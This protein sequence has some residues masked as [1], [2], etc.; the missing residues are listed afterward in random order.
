M[1]ESAADEGTP[2]IGRSD[3]VRAMLEAVDR[4]APTEATVLVTG[5]TG[6]G[7]ELVARRIHERS[8]RAGPFVAVNTASLATGVLESELF[9]HVRGAFTG[10]T[11]DRKGLFGAAEGGTLFLDEI[12]EVDNGVQHR[13]LRVLQERE[14]IPVGGERPQSIDV[15]IVAAT[16]R[17]LQEAMGAGHFRQDLYY[18]LNVFRIELPPLRAR[19]QDLP[20]LVEHFLSG[21]QPSDNTRWL[22]SPLAMRLLKAYPWPGNVRELFSVLESATIHADGSRIEAQHLPVDVRSARPAGDGAFERYR[23]GGTETDERSQIVQALDMAG[24]V[25]SRAAEMLGMGRTTLWRKLKEYGLA[26]D[27]EADATP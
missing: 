17:D 20:L 6:T 21:R 5:E 13:L 25:R 26:D 11:R 12:G 16:N 2:I 3:V 19:T 9:G 27:E 1:T 8:G 10:A 14:I 24:G 15:R 18:R 22:V 23:R 4:V 7:K